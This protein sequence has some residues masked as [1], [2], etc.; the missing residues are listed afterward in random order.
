MRFKAVPGLVRL[1]FSIRLQLYRRLERIQKADPEV[2][3]LL[4]EL[5]P[6]VRESAGLNVPR[7]LV[8]P[9][10]EFRQ[11]VHAV[12]DRLETASRT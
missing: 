3:R 10:L 12:R 8:A 9:Y 11:N 6:L 1:R 7:A 5:D 2:E 4:P